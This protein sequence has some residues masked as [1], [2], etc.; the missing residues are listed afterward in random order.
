MFLPLSRLKII[1]SSIRKER[2]GPR[3]GS[4]CITLSSTLPYHISLPPFKHPITLSVI[5]ALFIHYGYEKKFRSEIRDFI[6]IL[7]AIP[8]EF[9]TDVPAFLEEF[10]RF[11]K[12]HS[13]RSTTRGIV[14]L[15]T[16][17]QKTSLLVKKV[18]LTQPIV[19]VND[20]LNPEEINTDR[21]LYCV[22]VSGEHELEALPTVIQA[23]LAIKFIHTLNFENTMLVVRKNEH[24][25]FLINILTN[26]NF[27]HSFLKSLKKGE[28]KYLP[29]LRELQKIIATYSHSSVKGHLNMISKL[30]T[31]ISQ[32]YHTKPTYA[33]EL[34]PNIFCESIFKTISNGALEEIH[35]VRKTLQKTF[36]NKIPNTH[37]VFN[38][39]D[40]LFSHHIRKQIPQGGSTA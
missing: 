13:A 16:S 15:I 1:G 37:V 33:A 14:N 17:G 35:E 29:I 26:K 38:V 7:P 30:M 12:V 24:A 21:I 28:D 11:V 22:A 9:K 20:Y 36:M 39:C 34:L 31:P 18:K 6:N 3:R 32:E 23:K 5:R 4:V 25:D 10:P 8:P 27:F 2:P 40:V 19:V